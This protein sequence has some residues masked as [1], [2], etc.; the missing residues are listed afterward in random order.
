MRASETAGVG[1][2]QVADVAEELCWYH[3]KRSFCICIVLIGVEWNMGGIEWVLGFY[4]FGVWVEILNHL[5]T[6]Q[7]RFM[8]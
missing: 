8:F 5:C 6:K 4:S 7:G 1:G 3:A 2:A